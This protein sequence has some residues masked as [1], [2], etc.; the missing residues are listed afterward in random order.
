MHQH[1]NSLLNCSTHLLGLYKDRFLTHA[2]GG[3]N[4][5]QS[6]ASA[7][8]AQATPPLQFF[9]ASVKITDKV[10]TIAVASLVVSSLIITYK[11]R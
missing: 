2:S 9:G 3:T 8:Q 10:N 5:D 4:I 11:F 7:Q 6:E 1:I